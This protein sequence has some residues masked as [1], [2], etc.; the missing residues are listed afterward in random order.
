MGGMF[1][2]NNAT[3]RSSSI[4][5]DGWKQ[6]LVTVMQSGRLSSFGNT[7]RIRSYS[8]TLFFVFENIYYSAFIHTKQ[9][10]TRTENKAKVLNANMNT[11]YSF[12]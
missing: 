7:I 3:A 9:G 6:L 5:P 8:D 4:M 11:F 1:Y 12:Q 2:Y 10:D